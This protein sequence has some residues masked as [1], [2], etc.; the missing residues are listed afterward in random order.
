MIYRNMTE[1]S[2]EKKN[3]IEYGHFK[4]YSVVNL[5]IFLSNFDTLPINF[6]PRTF[7]LFI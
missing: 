5:D 6:H 7:N 3:P 2:V 1:I 4:S